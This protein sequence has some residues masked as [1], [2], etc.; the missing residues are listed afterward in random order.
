MSGFRAGQNGLSDYIWGG[1]GLEIMKKTLAIL[2]E[3]QG[4]GLIE[5]YAIGGGVAVLF[6]VE[7]VF[8][9]DLDIFCLIPGAKEGSIVSLSSICSFLKERGF[10]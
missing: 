9:S 5:A 10:F 6:Y 7:P 2:N 8:T 4:N 3:L 1:F